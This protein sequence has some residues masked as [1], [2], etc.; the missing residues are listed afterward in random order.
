M[1][2]ND[3]YIVKEYN[4]DNSCNSFLNKYCIFEDDEDD[5]VDGD[6]EDDECDVEDNEKVIEDCSK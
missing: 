3:L 4:F 1:D 6:N 5:E 2:E